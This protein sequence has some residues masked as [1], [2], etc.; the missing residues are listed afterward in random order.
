MAMALDAVWG[1]DVGTPTW[2]CSSSQHGGGTAFRP[3][4]PTRK[5]HGCGPADQSSWP[6]GQKGARDHPGPR[7]QELGERQSFSQPRVTRGHPEC[8]S[9]GSDT[10]PNFALRAT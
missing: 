9:P 7:G 6:R 4:P 2:G 8:P 1:S 10:K 5:G 3:L